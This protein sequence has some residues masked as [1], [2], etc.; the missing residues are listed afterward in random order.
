MATVEPTSSEATGPRI[1]I[2]HQH[3]DE[4]IVA[5]LVSMLE[6]AFEIGS[7][8]I[9]A[10]SVQGHEVGTGDLIADSLKS[11]IE[12]AE[13]VVGV[14]GPEIANSPYVL[15]ELARFIREGAERGV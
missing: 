7:T 5:A 3:R 14:I 2:S 15:F 13:L 1:F 6:C 12:H 11:D 9:R 8:D 10:T 4:K